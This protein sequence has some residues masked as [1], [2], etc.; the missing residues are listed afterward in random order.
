[1]EL[2]ELDERPGGRL[3]EARCVERE[4]HRRDGGA[5][6]AAQLPGVR[7]A[8][9]AGKRG[10]DRDHAVEGP[11]R[12]VVAAELE[13][14]V[15]DEAV[16]ARGVRRGGDRPPCEAQRLAELDAGSRRATRGRRGR[17]DRACRRRERCAERARRGSNRRRLRS[18]A[19]AAGTRGRGGRASGDPA[20]R[21]APSPRAGARSRRCRRARSRRERGPPTAPP[22]SGAAAPGS[23]LC[24]AEDPAEQDDQGGG[25]E[26]AEE[27]KKSSSHHGFQMS[28]A[29]AGKARPA[30]RRLPTAHPSD[31]GGRARARSPDAARPRTGT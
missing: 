3:G 14:R 15:A 17:S 29:R 18:R 26:G 9:V 27:E 16:A 24:L 22:A 28:R 19:S 7:D 20:G 11:E 13:E 5:R 8:G 21:P 31:C 6:P 10:L 2:A 23:R 4:L 1:M 30:A 25:Q 12:L